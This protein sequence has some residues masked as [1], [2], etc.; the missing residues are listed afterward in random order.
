MQLGI[1]IFIPGGFYIWY[2]EGWNASN[3]N[4]TLFSK[5]NRSA[6][7]NRNCRARAIITVYEY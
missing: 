4:E 2:F 6:Y 7:M 1:G 5:A 3:K